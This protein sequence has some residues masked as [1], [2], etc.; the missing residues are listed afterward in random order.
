MLKV[1]NKPAVKIHKTSEERPYQIE[2]IQGNFKFNLSTQVRAD[3]KV[4]ARCYKT[5]DSA[6]KGIRKTGYSEEI[7]ICSLSSDHSINRVFT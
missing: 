1:G 6:I 2:F 5:Y 4:T 7:I 3:R